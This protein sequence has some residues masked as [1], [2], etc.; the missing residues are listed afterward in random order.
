MPV[1]LLLILLFF[2]ALAGCNRKPEAAE[3][4]ASLHTLLLRSDNKAL[5]PSERLDA[6]QQSYNI[7][8]RQGNTQAQMKS[9]RMIG[10]SYWEMDSTDKAMA[11]FLELARLADSLGDRENQ[12]VALHNTGLLLSER[13]VYDSAI[14]YYEKAGDILEDI[15]DSVRVIEARIN[16][17]IAYK[18]LGMYAQAFRITS[19]AVDAMGD[20]NMPNEKATALTTLANVLK[21]LH[22]PKEALLYHRQAMDIRRQLNDSSGIAGSLNNIGNVHK[23]TGSYTEALK[24]YQQSLVLKRRLGLRRSATTTIDNIAETYLGLGLYKQAALY[25]REALA[26]RDSS[27]DKDAWMTSAARLA[28]IYLADDRYSDAETIALLIAGMSNTHD[29]RKQQLEHTLLLADIN[30]K[31]GHY[32]TAYTFSRKALEWKDSLF[33]TELSSDISSMNV[34]FDMNNKQKKLELAEQH[35]VIQAQR[36]QLQQYFLILMSGIIFLLLVITYLLYVS[37]K[38]RKRARERTEVLMSELNHRVANNMQIVSSILNLQTLITKDEQEIHV[39]ESGRRRIQAIGV[40]HRMLYQKEYTGT[41]DMHVFITKIVSSLQQA[42]WGDQGFEPVL[43]ADPIILKADQAI[44]LGLIINEALTNIFKYNQEKNNTLDVTIKFEK[45][46]NECCL[47]ITDNGIAWDIH[48]ARIS[49][50]G[51]GLLLIDML[52][53]QLKGTITYYREADHNFQSITFNKA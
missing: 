6:A 52:T 47:L 23:S 14:I 16:T 5:L 10:I 43:F 18:N 22:R 40:V 45:K 34:L 38:Q 24:Y 42:F 48:T 3:Q 13:S 29:Y 31:T 17:G 32:K 35:V 39:I 30:E 20:L 21:E 26:Q 49:K 19:G 44:P 46:A 4:K 36:V 27:A 8:I 51:L 41:V 11:Q 33:N 12:G 53:R 15:H 25:E 50:K 1:R 9:M 28:R 2:S 7:S 37:N